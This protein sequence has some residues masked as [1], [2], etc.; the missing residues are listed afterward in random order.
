MVLAS[1]TD[2]QTLLRWDTQ[3]G[4]PREVTLPTLRPQDRVH[5]LF[6]D[7]SGHHALVSVKGTGF[8]FPLY[9]HS[10]RAEAKE[11][12]KMKAK[13]RVARLAA[14]LAARH[15]ACSLPAL[16]PLTAERGD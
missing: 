1:T 12:P 3:T 9:V 4:A 7:P 2:S 10:S 6:V 11:L 15:P 5:N 16:A 14:A 13:V 8:G